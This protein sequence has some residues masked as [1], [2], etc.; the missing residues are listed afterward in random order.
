MNSNPASERELLRA[1]ERAA[2]ELVELASALVRIP[3][4]NIPPR[5]GE[6]A[7][8]RFV[9]EWLT[10][11]GI[12][13]ELIDL[14]KVP[15]LKEHPLFFE[16]AGY[17]RREYR[18]RPNLA[19]RLK[20]GGGG[21]TLILS[22]HSDTMPAG[23]GAWTRP[24]F[25]GEVAGDRLY[26]RGS[27][28]MKGGIAVQMLALKLLKQAGIRLAGDLIF[29]TVVDEEHAGANG[30]LANRLAGYLGDGVLL[31]EP[32]SLA[33]YHAHKGFRIVHLSLQG[34]S[35]MS[36]AGEQLANPV[37]AVGP[38]IECFQAFRDQRRRSAP[39]LPEYAH[40]REPAPVFL[41]KLQAGEFSLDIPMQIPESCVL[42][43][44]WQ[45]LPGESRAEIEK[46][47]FDFLN[48]WVAR[49]PVFEPFRLTHR[50]S[51]RW[52][53]GTR[54]APD[55]PL[56]TTLREAGAQVMP[57][58]PLVCGAPYPCDLFVFN[59][60]G[61][62]GCVIGPRGAN[63]HGADEYVE[64]SSLVTLLKVLLLATVRFCGAP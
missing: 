24:P 46:E 58:P 5:G 23:K 9:Q 62:P 14:E 7:G 10:G 42:E 48:A 27:F 45:T 17:E 2:P 25:G 18:E 15:G 41:N 56:V 22:G 59:H 50:F 20:G 34:K 12:A 26:G 64:I 21:K 43:V 54:I 29:E 33:I 11:A 52:M 63:C 6:L 47:F 3:S 61:I 4:E 31:A 60:F 53:P 35:G 8:Q 16:G 39:A 36:F 49:H 38:L 37:E 13:A 30:T 55:H 44:Y 1:A 32:S 57:Q 51:H 19:A 40:D 28:D